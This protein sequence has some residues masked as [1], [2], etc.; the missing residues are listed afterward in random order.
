M[1]IFY[2]LSFNFFFLLILFF[3]FFFF[4]LNVK[5]TRQFSKDPLAFYYSFFL[6]TH[7]YVLNFQL[8]HFNLYSLILIFF[9]LS[10]Y[11][12]LD[13]LCYVVI[14]SLEVILSCYNYRILLRNLLLIDTL[15]DNYYCLK[16]KTFSNFVLVLVK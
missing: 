8:L 15:N 1:F 6:S 13:Y 11:S 12:K 4:F 16:T 2:F 5:V 14:L 3:F 7:N 9:I 10:K